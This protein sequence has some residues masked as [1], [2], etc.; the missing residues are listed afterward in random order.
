MRTLV[1]KL[2]PDLSNQDPCNPIPVL[3]IIEAIPEEGKKIL[4]FEFDRFIAKQGKRFH[5]GSILLSEIKD[6]IVKFENEY[7]RAS[8]LDSSADEKQIQVLF[9][10]QSLITLDIYNLKRIETWIRPNQS[11]PKMFRGFTGTFQY[12]DGKTR[13]RLT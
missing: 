5:V 10:D 3:T 8:I 9:Y 2:N 12:F 4:A 11:L 7:G 1:A 6:L 13:K